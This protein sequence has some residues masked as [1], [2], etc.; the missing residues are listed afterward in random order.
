MAE[1]RGHHQ[2]LVLVKSL[3]GIEHCPFLSHGAAMALVKGWAASVF[4][5]PW[6]LALSQEA[7]S[8]LLHGL[9]LPSS[10]SDRDQ[11]D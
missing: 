3:D 4:V 10:L 5:C 9:S 7:L 6:R 1:T 11:A 2:A 8:M